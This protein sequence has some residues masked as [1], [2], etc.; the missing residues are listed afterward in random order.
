M[1]KLVPRLALSNLNDRLE[2]MPVVVIGGMR[3]SGKT[4]LVKDLIQTKRQFFSLDNPDILESVHQ[5]PLSLLQTDQLIT[6]DEVQRY[7]KL[8]LTI[9][10][11]VD[12]KQQFGTISSNW[13]S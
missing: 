13:L 7:P 2:T 3:Q 11:I 12:K 10:Q 9:K 1:N 6:I 8:L 5:Q 4:T